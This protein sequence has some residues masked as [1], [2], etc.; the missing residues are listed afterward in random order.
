[1]SWSEGSGFRGQGSGGSHRHS[2]GLGHLNDDWRADWPRRHACVRVRVSV[3]EC[4][5]E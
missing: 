3:R 2:H 5:S 1:M 4:V